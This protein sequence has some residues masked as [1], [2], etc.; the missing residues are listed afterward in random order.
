M[1]FINSALASDRNSVSSVSQVHTAQ[2]K[3]NSTLE[4][5]QGLK[6]SFPASTQ[7]IME[8]TGQYLD[9]NQL[10]LNAIYTSI[11]HDWHIEG[12]DY[13]ISKHSSA[14]DSETYCS[15]PVDQHHFP[16]FTLLFLRFQ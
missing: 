2:F 4:K 6:L 16:V 13:L 10:Y 1:Q 8:S 7:D 9:E 3:L 5:Q 14:G 15:M 12:L 11:P